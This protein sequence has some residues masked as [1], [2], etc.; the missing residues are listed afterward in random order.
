[1]SIHISSIAYCVLCY[2]GFI[3][4][5]KRQNLNK[6]ICHSW[7]YLMLYIRLNTFIYAPQIKITVIL[8]AVHVM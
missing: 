3:K 1:M 6:Y 7:L 8:M 4:S 5:W 2:K